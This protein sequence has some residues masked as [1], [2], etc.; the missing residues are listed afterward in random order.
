MLSSGTNRHLSPEDSMSIDHQHFHPD[1][2]SLVDGIISGDHSSFRQLFYRYHKELSVYALSICKDTDLGN[3]VVQEVFFNI[4]IRR[5][6]WTI[7]GSLKAYL[8]RAVRNE[9]LDLL[10]KQRK[11]R[12]SDSSTLEEQ[13]EYYDAEIIESSIDVTYL[14]KHRGELVARIWKRVESMPP[15]RRQVFKLYRIHGLKYQEIADVMGLTRKTVENHMARALDD[16]RHTIKDDKSY[17]KR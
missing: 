2:Q 14:E 3:D 17:K 12:V 9:A 16:L 5:S 13:T 10:A 11:E 7:N 6:R 4:W 15:K 1:D 8:F